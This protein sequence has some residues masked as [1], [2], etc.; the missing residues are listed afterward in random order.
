MNVLN[1]QWIKV[2]DETL[3]IADAMRRAHSLGALTSS[4]RKFNAGILSIMA[5][6]A[7]KVFD[8]GDFEARGKL[9][10]RGRFSATKLDEYFEGNAD[11]FELFGDNPWMQPLPKGSAGTVRPAIAMDGEWP[12]NTNRIA[13]LSVDPASAKPISPARAA[14]LVVAFQM[15]GCANGVSS[16]P[17]LPNRSPSFRANSANFIPIGGNLFETIILNIVTPEMGVTRRREPRDDLSWNLPRE[18]PE[19]HPRP[20]RGP[21]HL[22]TAQSQDMRLVGNDD[23]VTGF[24]SSSSYFNAKSKATNRLPWTVLTRDKAKKN[25]SNR[26]YRETDWMERHIILSPTDVDKKSFLISPPPLV[27]YAIADSVA[28]GVSLSIEML[29]VV[30]GGKGAFP[31]SE[32]SNSFPAPATMGD[33]QIPVE[34]AAYGAETLGRMIARA[35]PNSDRKSDGAKLAR[36]TARD[37]FVCA[38]GREFEVLFSALARG[39]TVDAFENGWKGALKSTATRAFYSELTATEPDASGARDRVQKMREFTAALGRLTR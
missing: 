24:A 37:E 23:G 13:K 25:E 6:I 8:I 36:K 14:Q 2:D 22:M 35:R 39:G 9:L 16:E 21:L 15:F 38:C 4:D 17:K 3:G 30:V 27:K 5:A 26:R 1:D 28:S 34:A 7:A 19:N 20:M 31:S 18:R 10:R 33:W 32:H 29:T 12:C 11:K